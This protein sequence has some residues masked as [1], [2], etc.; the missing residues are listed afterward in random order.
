MTDVNN[1]FCF[2]RIA[3]VLSIGN[4]FKVPMVNFKVNK[5]KV[6]SSFWL[7][8]W[9]FFLF[10]AFGFCEYENP[11]GTLRCIRLLNG[12]QIQDKKLVVSN[13]ICFLFVFL[14]IIKKLG[15][16]HDSYTYTH[17]FIYINTW[18]FYSVLV[19]IVLELPLF[20][21]ETLLLGWVSS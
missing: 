21:V 6:I 5:K 11:E 4:E 17:T 3:A 12:W 20:S 13:Y 16:Y 9:L 15:V 18:V 8:L 2:L 10:L 7:N 14:S 19:R 1:F